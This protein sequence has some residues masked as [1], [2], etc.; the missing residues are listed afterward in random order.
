MIKHDKRIDA[1]ISECCGEVLADIGCDHGYV[2]VGAVLSGR[3]KRAVAIDISAKSLEKT[4]LLS[5]QEGVSDRV[6]CLCGNGF[7]PLDDEADV[8]VIAGMGGVEIISVLD[9]AKKLPARLVLCPHQN[10]YE[11][12]K[13]L[14]GKFDIVKDYTVCA[15][16]KFYPV[17]VLGEGESFYAEDEFF[18]GKDMPRGDDYV[19][20]L[21]ARRATLE[22]RFSTHRVPD[23]KLR[24]EYEEVTLRC[25]KLKI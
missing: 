13:R 18:Y 15:A 14:N 19:A 3:V 21:A 25:S 6:R 9:A 5:E 2:A 10:A 17:I 16:G 20:M 11:L 22:E 8:A 24:A 4:R 7:A 12:R 1:L 23:G